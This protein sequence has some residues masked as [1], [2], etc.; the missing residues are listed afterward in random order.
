[1]TGKDHVQ[2]QTYMTRS[3]DGA[4]PVAHRHV[5]AVFEA[6]G[7]RAVADPLFALFELF[8]QAEVAWNCDQY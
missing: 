5:I 3:N 2:V 6:I 4:I 1:M 8:K 7:A